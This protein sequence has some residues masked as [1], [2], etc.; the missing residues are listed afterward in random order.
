[1]KTLNYLIL[2]FLAILVSG[3]HSREVPADL[4]E[5]LD[6]I[7]KEAV[8]QGGESLCDVT[9]KMS[10]GALLIAR[11]VTDMPEAKERIIGLLETRGMKYA[12][13]IT[14]LP[15]PAVVDKPWG[16]VSVSVCNMRSRRSHTSELVTQ[17]LMGT[18]VQ[19][20]DKQG[21]WL[22]IRTPDFY[23]GWTDDPVAELSDVEHEAWKAGERLNYTG[24]TGVIT[25]A[26]GGTVSDAVFGI[27]LARTGSRGD[28]WTVAL[29][30]GRTGEVKKG[31]TEDFRKW[32]VNAS[33]E[34]ARLVSFAM[35]FMGTPYLWGGT[36]TKML[37]CSGLTKTVY[38]YGGVILTRDA[39]GQMRYGDV[40]SI[41]NP[42]E[43]LRPGDL[44]FWGRERNGRVS[45]THTGLYIGDGE[46]I[47]SSALVRINSFDPGKANYNAYLREILQGARRVTGFTEGKGLQRLSENSWYF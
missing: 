41:D 29:P 21:G 33:I 20:L 7:V 43:T 2:L 8:P 26:G 44:L 19:I 46:Y 35:Q 13:S 16:L 36:S 10:D 27:I 25:D 45:I 18:P 17:A 15:D 5:Q 30:D 32:A 11:G 3:C 9:F 39:S 38:Y 6:I 4:Q 28:H 40:V 14:L 34:P 42:L 22:L 23:T 24:Y 37:D 31:E 1:M 12:D 47:H